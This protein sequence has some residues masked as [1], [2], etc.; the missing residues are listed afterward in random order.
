ML[1]PAPMG[2]LITQ[3]NAPLRRSLQRELQRACGQ[4]AIKERTLREAHLSHPQPPLLLK[5]VPELENAVLFVLVQGQ[6][7]APV[8]RVTRSA[9][10]AM[11][12]EYAQMLHEPGTADDVVI[13]GA[14]PPVMD[15]KTLIH[16]SPVYCAVSAF[17][18]WSRA[19][20]ARTEMK[21]PVAIV[22]ATWREIAEQARELDGLV[23][24]RM[25][26][27]YPVLAI[28]M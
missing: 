6:E 15:M 10:R 14:L 23:I 17:T 16:S 25:T 20:A 18:S 7:D 4:R 9:V 26:L 3:R 27:T 1:N 8:T 24:D 5:V 11:E 22:A 13:L 12:A 28:D 2:G 19:W 21:L